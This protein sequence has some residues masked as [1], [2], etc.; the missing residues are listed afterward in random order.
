MAELE[1][2]RKSKKSVELNISRYEEIAVVNERV[3]AGYVTLKQLTEKLKA[4]EAQIIEC[5]DYL[6]KIREDYIKADEYKT[7][8]DNQYSELVSVWEIQCRI[9]TMRALIIIMMKRDRLILMNLSL[10]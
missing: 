3:T 5:A 7:N 8:V 9:F 6:D 4:A 10:R 1:N 2:V